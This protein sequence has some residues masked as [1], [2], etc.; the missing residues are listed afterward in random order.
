MLDENY[1]IE[2]VKMSKKNFRTISPKTR[3]LFV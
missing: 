3:I 1:I 2:D